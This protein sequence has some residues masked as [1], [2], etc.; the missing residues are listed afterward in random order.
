[1]KTKRFSKELSLNKETIAHLNSNEM[2]GV[3]GGIDKPL[4]SIVFNCNFSS[5]TKPC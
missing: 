1:M 3:N 2:K 5:P 4:V